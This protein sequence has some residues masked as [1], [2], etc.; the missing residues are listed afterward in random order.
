MIK[1]VTC[2][3][4]YTPSYPIE[5]S[6]L[7]KSYT[8]HNPP[9]NFAHF[10]YNRGAFYAEEQA[11]LQRMGTQA[12]YIMFK[13]ELLKKSVE[14]LE[15]DYLVFADA[16]DV[17]CTGNIS[18]LPNLFDLEKY[19]VFS[20][21]RNDWPKQNMIS[22]WENYAGYKQHDRENR[23]FLNSG[24]QLAKKEK[25][26][27]L[28]RSCLERFCVHNVKGHG[29]DQG[30]FTWHYNTQEEPKIILDYAKVFAW[31]TY[32]SNQVDY[33]ES[34]KRLVCN[35]YGTCP[36]FIHDNGTNY[37]GQRFVQKFNLDS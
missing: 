30:V 3:W 28:L 31:S 35:Q 36:L 15:T 11:Y 23:Y 29:G 32:D 37:G 9:E 26:I 7:Y 10:H 20:A 16:T 24:V 4:G 19:V 21:E 33:H 25:Y 22:H 6:M 5:Q 1:L 8:K 12:E 18:H 17:F 27:Q 14:E 34:N 13:I 2:T